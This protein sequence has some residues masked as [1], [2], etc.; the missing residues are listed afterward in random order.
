MKDRRQV[1]TIPAANGILFL[2]I[3]MM[4]IGTF[5][6]VANSIMSLN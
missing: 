2:L 5:T 1:P 4:K 6:A 3:A